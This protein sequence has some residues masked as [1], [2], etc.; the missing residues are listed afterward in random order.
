MSTKVTVN[1]GPDH[2]LYFEIFET[3]K[4]YLTLNKADFVA[5]PGSVTV[6]VPIEIWEQVRVA[7]LDARSC[8]WD[9]DEPIDMDVPDN[10]ESSPAPNVSIPEEREDAHRP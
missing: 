1:H 4:I 9:E 2:H 8:W 5:R 7:P 3:E 10:T 6:A